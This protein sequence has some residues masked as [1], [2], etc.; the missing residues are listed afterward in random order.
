MKQGTCI[1][2]TK[3]VINDKSRAIN[4]KEIVKSIVVYP[5]NGNHASTK[6]YHHK[7]LCSSTNNVYI[8]MLDKTI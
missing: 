1:K 5:L 3:T 4:N 7:V 8:T 2:I 6:N